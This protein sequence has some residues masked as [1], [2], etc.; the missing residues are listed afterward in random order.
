MANEEKVSLRLP[1]DLR[2]RAEALAKKLDARPDQ[3]GDVSVS[4]VLRKALGLGL[5]ILERET[6]KR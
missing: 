5:E 1:P 2:R 6:R 4:S 3:V